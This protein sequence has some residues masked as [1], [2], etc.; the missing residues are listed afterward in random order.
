MENWQKFYY[1]KMIKSTKKISCV[2]LFLSFTL[3]AETG[4]LLPGFA[5]D[6]KFS[7]QTTDS[8]HLPGGS[9]PIKLKKDKSNSFSLP[10]GGEVPTFGDEVDITGQRLATEGA[11][12]KSVITIK[13]KDILKKVRDKGET[14]LGFNYLY[15][16][17]SYSDSLNVFETVFD[18][19]H[20]GSHRFGMLQF[21][22]SRFFNRK[23]F[24]LYWK[25]NLGVGYNRGKGRFV[26]GEIADMHF[27]LWS[28]P[29]DL[30]VGIDFPL[31]WSSVMLGVAAGPS[32][33]GLIQSRDD[34]G[35]DESGRR[36]RQFSFGYTY[37]L[38]ASIDMA[39]FF[40]NVAYALF[41]NYSVS[42]CYINLIARGQGYSGFQDSDI[43]ISGISFG[44]G[45]TLEYL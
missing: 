21:S 5:G 16:T 36:K 32:I 42:R 40:P 19:D 4:Q 22:A 20:T 10:G 30:M 7:K 3:F 24:D 12:P 15:D 6:L 13:R 39:S 45:L 28:I 9:A 27:Q 8:P 44:L 38:K 18:G 34:F 37:Q 33:M 23:V 25:V 17:F 31:G 14:T 1:G 11:Q 26:K 35:S 43:S 29:L 41:D 2:L